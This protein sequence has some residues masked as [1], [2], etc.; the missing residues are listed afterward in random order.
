MPCLLYDGKGL[1]KT[2]RFRN[3]TYIGDPLNAIRI[4]NEKEVDELV[5]IDIQASKERR[6]PPFKVITECASECFMPFSYGGG[7]TEPK[8]FAELYRS[9][10]EKVIVNTLC[11]SSP[12][13]VHAAVREYGSS[14]V[15]GAVDYKKT[16]LGGTKVHSA[17]G[18]ST[19]RTLID[20]CR[21]LVDDIGVGE[22]FL[23]SVDRDGTWSG[24]DTAIIKQ[25]SAA[26]SA[27]VIACGGA[28]TVDHIREV[29]ETTHASAAAIGS[30]AV[31]QKKGMG[32]LISFPSRDAVLLDH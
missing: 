31:Y 22:L 24:F 18:M 1:V 21:F 15:V 32:V 17:S 3:P 14:S 5:L 25:I 28:G 29:L 12:A 13:T 8:D 4:F 7:V 6:H 16:F 27:P 9:G 11:L 26:V 2:V 30:M 10:V 20:H 19:R 23:N